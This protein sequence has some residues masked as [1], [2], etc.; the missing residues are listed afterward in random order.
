MLSRATASVRT[1]CADA[2]AAAHTYRMLPNGWTPPPATPPTHLPYL[3]ERTKVGKHLPVYSI[4]RN[5]GT[6]VTTR[7]RKVRGD[8]EALADE[9]KRVCG[10]EDVW[11]RNS[12]DVYIKGK[13]VRE[14]KLALTEMGF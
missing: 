13:R 1:L 9:L 5:D 14:I 8:V 7:V 2:K 12:Q 6:K 4:Y 10:T 11:T 3:V